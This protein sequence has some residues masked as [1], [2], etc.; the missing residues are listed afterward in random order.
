MNRKLISII[1]PAHNEENVI[2]KC[3][4]SLIRQDFRKKYEIIVINDG[5]IDKTKKIV[6]RYPVKLLNFKKDHSASFA[7]NQGSKIAKGKYLI[8]VDADMIVPKN[9]V[10]RIESYLPFDCL[11]YHVLSYKPKTIFQRAW[12]AYRKYIDKPIEGEAKHCIHCIKKE[13]F[14]KVG[15]YNEK[16]FYF[17]DS[18]LRGRILKSTANYRVSDI[19]VLH[20]DPKG[21][22]D[23]VRQR[24][25]HAKGILSILKEKNDIL[26]LKYFVPCLFLPITYVTS[27]LFLLY[28]VLFWLKFAIRTKELINSFLWFFLDYIGRFISLFY[29]IKEL[30]K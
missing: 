17:E 6:K 27:I 13:L 15:G 23:F 30:V 29:F 18:D 21:L 5:S 7:R 24:K 1:I 14:K 20:I 19:M 3:L 12:S 11:S 10:K 16:I 4:S 26:A 9:F 2:G 28:L 25:W 8:F 22:S